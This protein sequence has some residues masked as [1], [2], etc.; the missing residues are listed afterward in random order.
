MVLTPSSEFIFSFGPT[1]DRD[2]LDL[3]TFIQM[4]RDGSDSS[5]FGDF[6]DRLYVDRIDPNARLGTPRSVILN[7]CSDYIRSNCSFRYFDA[8]TLRNV[9]KLSDPSR[10]EP[11]NRYKRDIPDS[12]YK[13]SSRSD[14]SQK[15]KF[16]EI[17][18]TKEPVARSH[19]GNL[20]KY[21]DHRRKNCGFFQVFDDSKP[22][23]GSEEATLKEIRR[24]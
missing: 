4:L 24:V 6:Y 21:F 3:R 7:A 17:L 12:F 8:G 15:I 22:D 2:P 20:R 14:W 19:W 13:L 5:S 11:S 10:Y 9:W 1:K 16:S 18:P 23:T